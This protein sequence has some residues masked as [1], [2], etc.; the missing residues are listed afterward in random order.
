MD[1]KTMV[2][3]GII[4]VIM[5]VMGIFFLSGKKEKKKFKNLEE[6]IGNCRTMDESKNYFKIF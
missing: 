5:L 2:L 6:Y 1:K 4:A 3:I